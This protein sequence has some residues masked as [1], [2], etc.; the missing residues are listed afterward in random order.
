MAR[1]EDKRSDEKVDENPP[2]EE[3]EV[4]P[5]G[6]EVEVKENVVQEISQYIEDAEGL[7]DVAVKLESALEGKMS[8]LE[9][10]LNKGGR[11]DD[12]IQEEYEDLIIKTATE[13]LALELREESMREKLMKKEE[14]IRRK[15]EDLRRREDKIKELESILREKKDI[16]HK[17]SSGSNMPEGAPKEYEAAINEKDK[18]IADLKD[19]LRI[20]EGRYREAEAKIET[21][22]DLTDAKS[23]TDKEV[24]LIEALQQ[25][26]KEIRDVK[27][28]A[29]KKEREVL[30]NKQKLDELEGLL[31]DREEDL[32]QREE[33][34]MKM[35]ENLDTKMAS[36]TSDLS[37]VDLKLQMEHEVK[38]RE[39]EL[40]RKYEME[41]K[42]KKEEFM[43]RIEK[44]KRRNEDLE[45][46][47]DIIEENEIK[48]SALEK[49]L[50]ER[51]DELSYLEEK[52]KRKEE[53]LVE[54]RRRFEQERKKIAQK[55]KGVS[56]GE[57][58]RIK[59]VIQQKNKEMED[60]EARLRQREEFIRKKEREIRKKQKGIMEEEIAIEESK[61]AQVIADNISTGI[62]RLDDL[63]YDGVPRNTSVLLTGNKYTGEEKYLRLFLV[64]GLRKQMPCI[65]FSTD[66]E[67]Q[68]VRDRMKVIVPNIQG[69]ENNG[70][71]KY[72]DAFSVK[73][74]LPAED[75]NTFYVKDRTNTN[76]I[77]D[78]LEKAIEEIS[79]Q[80][81][82]PP[83]MKMAFHSLTSVLMGKEVQ[84]IYEFMQSLNL[85]C[86]K[87]KGNDVT[88]MFAIQSGPL[89]EELIETIKSQ[90]TATIILRKD[91]DAYKL[92][93]V[94]DIPV[95]STDAITY[96]LHRRD[97]KITGALKTHKI[98]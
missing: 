57:I 68:S 71:L 54:E 46:A 33:E 92:Q 81:D 40:K 16:I 76:E 7:E 84:E 31:K 15:L 70:L 11:K 3:P 95:R 48:I 53:R 34:V 51:Q 42:K 25:K 6:G 96:E 98:R 49:T 38:K 78:V 91:P 97:I 12:D 60:L 27:K 26:E 93:V 72:I 13:Y 30:E 64:D 63:F 79:S 23:G 47:A 4:A 18:Q 43:R 88:A 73:N 55:L 14:S 83:A 44:L 85:K 28:E 24:K 86:H 62:G 67:T 65:Y 74:N 90:M 37:D 66:D 8:E 21:M 59:A 1:K 94:T 35:E 77:L 29:K 75:D 22:A 69:Y 58:G 19:K 61:E 17:V 41:M 45:A 5:N 36:A 52:L 39:M 56:G 50:R 82:E 10:A 9:S 2:S 89:K 20:M 32:K 80:Y 87:I